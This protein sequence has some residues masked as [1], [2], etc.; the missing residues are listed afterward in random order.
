MSNIKNY[1]LEP[2][3]NYSDEQLKA[4][5]LEGNNILVSAAAGSGKTKV[6]VERIVK[7]LECGICDINEML[8]MTF[9]RA[10][11]A[12][13]KDKIKKRIDE[14]L[15]FLK[16]SYD[17]KD[18]KD[19]IRRLKNQSLFIQNANVSTI[20]SFCKRLVDE[21]F[22]ALDELDAKYRVADENELNILKSDLLDRFLESKYGQKDEEYNVEFNDF[23]KCYFTKNDSAIRDMILNGIN[24]IDTLP[25]VDEF[26]DKHLNHYEE[27]SNEIEKIANE[28]DDEDII[29]IKNIIKDEA[30]DKYKNNDYILLVLL[31]EFYEIYN[32]EKSNR[33]IV[34]ISDFQK[35]ALKLLKKQDSEGNFVLANKYQQKFKRI[36]VDEYQDTSDIQEEILRA[37]SN[38][39]KNHNVFMVGDVKQCIY[40]FRNAKPNIFNEKY[41]NYKDIKKLSDDVTNENVL[42]KLNK[43]YRSSQYV[44]DTTNTIFE[45]AMIKEFGNIDYN[46]EG[47][48]LSHGRNEQKN[49]YPYDDKSTNIILFK[50]VSTKMDDEIQTEVRQNQI[51]QGKIEDSDDYELNTKWDKAQ[52]ISYVFDIIQDL[53]DK[54]NI[55]YKDIV[56]LHP[57]PSSL[58][59][60]YASE[61]TRRDIPFAGNLK[62]GFYNSYEIVLMCAILSVIDNPVN[63]VDLSTVLLS[64]LIKITDEELVLIKTINKSLKEKKSLSSR[65][66][67]LYETILSIYNDKELEK[68]LLANKK[69]DSNKYEIL[70]EKIK[71]FFDLFAELRQY[72]RI[73]S[74]SELISIIYDKANIYNYMRSM[75]NGNIRISNLDLFLQKANSFESTSYSGLFN[76][77]RYIE[78]IRIN[79]ID[80][81]PAAQYDENDDVVRLVSIHSSKGL[82]YP[83]V[84]LPRMES[85]LKPRSVT[86]NV[87]YDS[88]YGVGLMYINHKERYSHESIKYHLIKQK[89]EDEERQEKIRLLYVGLTRAS[90]KLILTML[91]TNDDYQEVVEEELKEKKTT[92]RKTTKSTKKE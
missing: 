44:I 60:D 86:E 12:D 70:K 26:F 59:D 31:K 87:L 38:D 13:M 21:N 41:E 34:S 74:I 18:K 77:L 91:T 32:K 85:R 36:M 66:F 62:A 23:F 80:E 51:K 71:Y 63:D 37:I 47:V 72:Q 54:E 68:E 58:I 20:D 35:Y 27:V 5:Y 17:E 19:R 45:K 42:I 16:S 61:A 92:K 65:F 89:K 79:D 50:N 55:K 64:K 1:P 9:T 2:G 75:K 82:Q 46:E 6:L 14:R 29:F 7:E 43:N 33:R 15:K 39:F 49:E 88:E 78:Q 57:T 69:I 73:K 8:V 83:V 76:F 4:I 25:Y 90:E 3:L 24:F 67:S 10:A 56:I 52:K 48:A 81:S 22:S 28:S 53:H 40:A 30:Q 11:T 84:I